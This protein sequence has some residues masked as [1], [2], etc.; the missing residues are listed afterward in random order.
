M[1]SRG[2][3]GEVYGKAVAAS[4]MSSITSSPALFYAMMVGESMYSRAQKRNPRSSP[5]EL[6]VGAR[7]V[8]YLSQEMRD[9]VRAV[10]DANIWAVLTLGY[11]GKIAPSRVGPKYPRQSFLKEL[12]SIHIYCRMEIVY[13]HVL[14]LM[15]L[16]ELLG[17]IHNIK[18]PGMA[19]VLSL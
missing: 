12:Q 15:K 17:G 14:G 1:V 11:S 2:P 6:E 16:V 10:S 3:S 4:I 9:P 13:A 19:Q 8:Q 7:A 5:I 18:T